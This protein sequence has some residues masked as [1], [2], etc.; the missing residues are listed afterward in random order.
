MDAND[1]A[2]LVGTSLLMGMVML[3]GRVVVGHWWCTYGRKT[4]IDW[5]VLGLGV[6]SLRMAALFAVL[7]QSQART[8]NGLVYAICLVYMVKVTVEH[9]RFHRHGE[10]SHA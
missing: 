10:G 9:W 4:L 5:M 1:L 2:Q 7:D 3:T 6:S 8:W